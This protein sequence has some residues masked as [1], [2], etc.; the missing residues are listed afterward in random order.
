MGLLLGAEETWAQDLHPSRRLSPVGIAQTYVGEA[1][2]KVVYGRPY[3]RGRDIFGEGDAFLIPYGKIWRTG[4]NEATEITL[5]AP[6]MVAGERLEAGTYALFTVP[7]PDEWSIRFSPQLGL[8]GLDRRTDTG[9]DAANAYDPSQ[10]VLVVTATPMALNTTVDPFTITFEAEGTTT[11]L[12]LRWA[13]TE[14]R[15]RLEAGV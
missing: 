10:D 5:T 4:D 12:V 2:V 15:V 1:Y 9:D 6:L 14:V 3:I 11:D 13:R 7:G 8:W